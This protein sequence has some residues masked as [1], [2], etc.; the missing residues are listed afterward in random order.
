MYL[1]TIFELFTA[2]CTAEK[3]RNRENREK[4]MDV[5]RLILCIQVKEYVEFSGIT[6]DI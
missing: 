6:Y 4:S 5:V 1:Y 2:F 3:K